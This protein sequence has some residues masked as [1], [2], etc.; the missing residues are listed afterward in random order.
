MSTILE[1]VA[2]FTNEPIKAYSDPADIAAM[3]AALADVRAGFGKKYP[4]VIDGERV[5][6]AKTIPSINRRTKQRSSARFPPQ[7]SSRQREPL[8]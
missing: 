2:P 4:L 5:H 8:R 6:T 7:R 3:Q 1:A